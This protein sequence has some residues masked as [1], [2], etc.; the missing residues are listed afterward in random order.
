MSWTSTPLRDLAAALAE[1]RIDAELLIR[2]SL[3]RHDETDLGAYQ[4]WCPGAALAKAQEIDAMR[5][6]G[7]W[8][9]PLAGIPISVKDLLGVVGLPTYAGSPDRLPAEW[10]REGFLVRRMQENLA[11]VVGKTKMVE[12]AFGGLGQNPTWGTPINPWDAVERRVPGGSSCGAGVSLLEGSALVALGTDTACSVRVPA[13]MTG[14]VGFKPSQAQWP[15]DGIVPL[16]TTLDTVGFLTRTVADAAYFFAAVDPACGDP[17]IFVDRA[18]QAGLDGLR[19]GIDGVHGWPACEAGI[20]EVVEA[21]LAD[22]E[23]QGATLRTHS[24]P[25]LGA[26]NQLYLDASI[27]PPEVAALLATRLP[28]WLDRLEPRVAERIRAADQVSAPAY[29]SALAKR[30]R[31]KALAVARMAGIDVL[32]TPTTIL[33]PPRLSEIADPESYARANGRV[34]RTTNLANVLDFCAISIPC[35]LDD[36]GMPVGLQLLATAGEEERLLAYALAAEQVLGTAD[37]RLGRPPGLCD[38][39]RSRHS[40]VGAYT[41]G[42]SR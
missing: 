3:E 31:L 35:G 30:E 15:T 6:G 4:V 29:L 32:A 16:S 8:L 22:L 9:P 42:P 18:V 38:E 23:S 24:Y 1:G 5:R 28:G 25:E 13:S 20:A 14:T 40:Q 12:L 19:I 36:N 2:E 33:S 7:S 21:A 39:T 37:E 27:V 10:E 34:S 17:A 41:G 26:A 11:V